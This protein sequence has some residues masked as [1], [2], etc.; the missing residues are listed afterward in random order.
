MKTMPL[1]NIDKRNS[2]LGIISTRFVVSGG[3]R[4]LR[5]QGLY[6]ILFKTRLS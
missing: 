1:Q 3:V 5:E 2:D 4:W 6:R